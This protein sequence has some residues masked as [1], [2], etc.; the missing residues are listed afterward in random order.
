MQTIIRC[1]NSTA[2]IR[3]GFATEQIG[4]TPEFSPAMKVGPLDKPAR[5]ESRAARSASPNGEA[6]L[7]EASITQPRQGAA[8]ISPARKGW[9][10]AKFDPS[11]VGATHSAAGESPQALASTAKVHA[12]L[13]QQPDLRLNNLP[14]LAYKIQVAR[15]QM[16]QNGMDFACSR[17][18]G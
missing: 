11:P 18:A 3:S 17:S 8:E 4:G 15:R 5:E 16:A 2:D 12:A 7:P 14:R 9:E 13:S 6:G 10:N 1:R